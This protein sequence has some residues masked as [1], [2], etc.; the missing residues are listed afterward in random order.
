MKLIIA[1]GRDYNLTVDDYAKLTHLHLQRRITEE[2]CG[3]P[4]DADS[5][6]P[7]HGAD[8]CGAAWAW[9]HS[10]P[11]KDFAPDWSNIKRPG[12]VVRKRRDGKLYD[13]AA[14]PERNKQMAAYADAVA[15]FPGGAGTE[16]MRREAKAAGLE[17]FDFSAPL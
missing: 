12:A 8:Q 1:G 9:R 14:G 16:S 3:T 13:A 2:V 7:P 11:V 5:G 4:W 15:L 6:N 17:I 10:I